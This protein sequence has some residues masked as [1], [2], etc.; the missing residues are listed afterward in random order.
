V[1]LTVN[2]RE[3]SKSVTVLED[4]WMTER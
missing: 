4:I 3:Y 1:K 2:G